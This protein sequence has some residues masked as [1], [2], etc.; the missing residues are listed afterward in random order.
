MTHRVVVTGLGLISPLGC[1][2]ATFTRNLFAGTCGIGPIETIDSSRLTVKNAGEI[3]NFNAV[4]WMDAKA[5]PLMDRF[6][7]FAVAAAKQAIEASGLDFRANDELAEA[8]ACIIGSGVGGQ[9]T[10]EDNYTRLHTAGTIR[11]HPL[12]IPKLMISA[13]S[14][15]VSMQFG[16]KGPSYVI[17]SACSSANHAIG[18]AYQYVKSGLS[19][20]AVTGGTDA[21]VTFGTMK[22]WEALRVMAPDVCRP[23]SK[24]RNGM[25]LGEGAAVFVLERLEDAIERGATILA[26]IA[27]F[28]QSADARDLTSPDPAGAARAV[29]MA[30][31]DAQLNPTDL[32]YVNAHGTG[33]TINDL[34][35]TGVLKDVFGAH[36]SH[37]AISASKSQLG[38][39]LGA[40][41]AL[42][43]AATIAAI[44]AQTA[45]PTINYLEADPAC[46]LDYVPNVARPMR[47]D[48]AISN[49]FAFGGLNA[50]LAVKRFA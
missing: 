19:R 7:H 10:Q 33:T 35:E 15:H 45:P 24:G 44:G 21:C 18:V 26:E 28:G 42:E 5:A 23:F 47:I 9:N 32:Q 20:A 29:R 38:H 17:A 14:S 37:L 3:K 41:G 6:A 30:L 16:L 27:G 31:A 46:D 39:A 43:L 49:S 11:L 22:G 25:S 1:D 13:A 48:A 34:T 40:A 50:V 12:T 8:T 4:D 36:A 2:T